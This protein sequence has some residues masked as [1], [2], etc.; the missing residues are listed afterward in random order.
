MHSL[1]SCPAPGTSYA[2]DIMVA[3]DRGPSDD[4][5]VD[6][7]EMTRMVAEARALE[8]VG[9]ERVLELFGDRLTTSERRKVR[10]DSFE[11]G[12]ERFTLERDRSGRVLSSR[13]EHVVGGVR[14][15][16]E[17]LTLPQWIAAALARFQQ[18]MGS[19]ALDRSTLEQLLGLR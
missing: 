11:V 7:I 1:A 16:S 17:S 3:D 4:G 5:I 13:L 8:T 10:T 14:I 15:R 6:P 18:E 19:A 12:Q 2:L 9:L